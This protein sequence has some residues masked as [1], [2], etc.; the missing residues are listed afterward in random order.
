M[1]GRKR[2]GRGG[3]NA[4]EIP[5]GAARPDHLSAFLTVNDSKIEAKMADP[6]SVC[7]ALSA[8]LPSTVFMAFTKFLLTV[9]HNIILN[10]KRM[11]FRKM[12]TTSKV[13]NRKL[14]SSHIFCS[15]VRITPASDSSLCN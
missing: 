2:E 8:A 15:P 10:P 6:H 5:S 7:V 4:S 3:K 13:A 11:V 9:V 1:H 12:K 14:G